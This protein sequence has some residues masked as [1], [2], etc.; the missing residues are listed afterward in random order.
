MA[1]LPSA[2][3]Q[4]IKRG[5]QVLVES[6]A[7]SGAGYPDSDYA[8]AG[9]I[10]IAD[11]ASIFGKDT[12]DNRPGVDIGARSQVRRT[13]WATPDRL[14]DLLQPTENR[15]VVNLAAPCIARDP[16]AVGI[17]HLR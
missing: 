7:G 17:L 14:F 5:H 15:F 16:S 6:N 4:L 12:L 9:A 1:L 10:L 2:A 3:Y 8:Q 11:H 13:R